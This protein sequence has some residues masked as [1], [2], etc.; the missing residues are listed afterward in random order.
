MVAMAGSGPAFTF[1][2]VVDRPFYFAITDDQTD[3]VLFMG[4]VH[5]L[6]Q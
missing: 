5:E 1:E 3:S 6:G 2:F 4:A